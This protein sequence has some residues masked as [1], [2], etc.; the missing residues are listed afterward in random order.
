MTDP[1]DV[2]QKEMAAL[3][4]QVEEL[5]PQLHRA[6]ALLQDGQPIEDSAQYRHWLANLFKMPSF[7]L[8]KN[9]QAELAA[10]E[11]DNE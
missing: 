5:R 8:I 4:A 7:E 2:Y 10:A 3:A 6:Y 11:T 1:N 9:V